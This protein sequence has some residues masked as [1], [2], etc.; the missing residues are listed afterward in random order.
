MADLSESRVL[1]TGVALGRAVLAGPPAMWSYSSLKEVETC[2]LRYALFR[3][4]YPDLW[5]QHD[6]PRLPIPAAIQGDVLHGALEI[7]V[8]AFVKAGC[9]STRS[10][11]AVAVLRD[12]GGYTKVAEGV[13]AVRLARF[14]GYPRLSADRREQLTRRLTDWVREA[15]E[16]IQTYFNR[17]DLRSS[18]ASGTATVTSDP[19]T[20]YPARTGDH[21]E[22]ELVAEEFRLKG[23]VDLFS[24]GMDGVR[25][26]DFKT[27]MDDP[28]HHDQLRLYAL[29]W[30]ADG[31]VN[32]DA[33]P[34]KE[35]V[36]AYPVHE[37]AVLVPSAEGLGTL[38]DDVDARIEVAEA[39]VAADPP[40]ARLGEHCGLCSV[41][42]LCD[43][44]W[45]T[46]AARKAEVSD[47]AWY[48]LTGTVV[49]EHGVKSF[50]LRGDRTGQRCPGAHADLRLRV[51]AGEGRP[52]PRRPSGG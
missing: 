3:A 4:D 21:P 36:A 11:E 16:Q 24:V 43:P 33:L 23:G 45:T 2:P 50:V 37:V 46:R 47:G 38:G 22:K 42:G 40:T 49:R 35:L 13:L 25:I 1:E 12:L 14:E 28:A 6:Y 5:G 10:A 7:I 39:A 32:P 41:R 48:D 8:K 51:A 27:G 18:A 20:S 26:T 31:K 17:M 30:N 44:Y 29:L 9:P 34:V 19:A 52:H 15:R